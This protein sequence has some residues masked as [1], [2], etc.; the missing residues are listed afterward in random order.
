MAESH[1]LGPIEP[2]AHDLNVLPDDAHNRAL[3]QNVHPPDWANPQ[4][5]S[6]Y[7]LLVIGAGPAGLIAA[8]GAAGLSARVALVERE[9]MGGDCLNVGCVPSKALIRSARAYADVSDAA[10][11]GVEVPPGARANFA[12][13][14]ERMRRIRSAISAIDSAARYRSLGVDVFFG[15]GQF[16]G[17]DT[18][19]VADRTL[20][21][22]KAVIATGAR[23]S[24]PAIP[25]LAEVGCLTNE[26]VFSLTELPRR[27]AVVGAGPIGCE[28]AQVFARFGS[29]VCL[30]EAMHGIMPNDD[31][32][33]TEIV[34]Q[35][36]LRDGVKIICCGKDLR[37]SRDAHGKRLS[38]ES[39]GE[40]HDLSVD[41]ILLGVG[42]SPNVES[43]GLDAVGVEYDGQ[44]IKINDRLQTTNRRIYAAG[45]VCS[46]HRFTHAADAMAR[47]VIRNALFLGRA[48]L[49]DL[50]IPWC[51]YTDPEIAHVGLSQ[52]EARER[53]I[54]VQ[55]FVQEFSHVDRAV[56]DGDDAG[57]VKIHVRDGS[58]RI[59]GAT[60]VAR[61]AGEMISEITLA[62]SA[63]LGLRAIADT[64][65]PYPTQSEAIR[66][67][68]DAHNRTRLTPRVKRLFARWLA[69]TR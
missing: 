8:S 44:G 32:Q 56:L 18:F 37:I 35:A 24:R 10:Q 68:A 38:V 42:R 50:V 53:G 48:K 45:D 58:D 69:W 20:R 16:V 13:V 61:H 15:R 65:H 60:I 5:A 52:R 54:A 59:V 21:F 31:P 17:A 51:T 39:H 7:D 41:E 67:A 30:I 25:G 28:L 11:F 34:R 2:H 49:S 29:E 63:G 62:M 46:R 33:C 23:A 3:L 27:L 47:I 36:L 64:I 22:R 66:R 14:M 1:S 26:N 19:Q 4:P 6:R 43:L 9:F 55:T 40:R 12:A 57:L